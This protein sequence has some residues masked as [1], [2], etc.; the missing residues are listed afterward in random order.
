MK[1]FW[2]FT[3]EDHFYISRTKRTVQDDRYLSTHFHDT[4]EM[5]YLIEGTRTYFIQDTNYVMLRSI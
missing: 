3:M 2:G 1:T 5:Y 4:Y